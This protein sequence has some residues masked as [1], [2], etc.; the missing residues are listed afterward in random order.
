MLKDIEDLQFKEELNEEDREKILRM[1]LNI[2][3]KLQAMKNG[4]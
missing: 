3:Q 2:N 1:K 4:N